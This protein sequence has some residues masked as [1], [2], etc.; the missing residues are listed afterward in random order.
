MAKAGTAKR[1]RVHGIEQ[2][3]LFQPDDSGWQPIEEFPDLRG[4]KAI[5]IDIESQD[6]NLDSKGPGFLRGDAKMVGFSLATFDGWKRYYPL[7]HQGGD[8]MPDPEKALRWLKE[9]VETPNVK[10]IGAN[11]TYELEGLHAAGINLQGDMLDVQVLQALLNEEQEGGYSLNNLCKLYL[12]RGKEEELLDEACRTYGVDKGGLWALPARYVGPYGADDAY[13]PMMIYNKQF[14]KLREEGLEAVAKIETDLIP[15]I[16]E[17]RKRGVRVDVPAAELLQTRL[18]KEE[19][20]DMDVIARDLKF[21]PDIWS[22][23][24]LKRVCDTK[25]IWD[26]PRT[27]KGN[28]SFKNDWLAQQEDPIFVKIGELRAKQKMR[29]DFVEG[30]ILTT[31]IRG[32]IH[33]QFH[34]TRRNSDSY[35]LQRT[36]GPSDGGDVEGT[37]SGRFSSTNPNLQQVPA[38]HPMWGKVIRALFVADVEE[39]WVKGDHAAQEPRLTAHIAK[40]INAPGADRI[41]EAYR[42]NP[43]LD[44][45][46]W[47]ADL[48]GISRKEAKTIN[49]GV[50]Y[51]MG[52]DKLAR[53]LGVNET[54]AKAILKEYDEAA[55]HIKWMN[56]R[57]M[58]TVEKRGFIRTITGRKRRFVKTENDWGRMV[59]K[60][61]HKAMNAGV[62]GSGAELIKGS[63][64]KSVREH[65]LYPSLTV[66]DELNWS[67]KKSTSLEVYGDIM[68]NCFQLHVQIRTELELGSSWGTL[69]KLKRE[70][71]A[72][73]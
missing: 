66:H 65:G 55:P 4:E 54:E 30:Q 43:D 56:T 14:D 58:E 60:G 39:E 34:S 50:A 57:A 29:R 53:S 17:M 21:A 18:L 42:E 2:G 24:D 44:T 25:G 38:R 64:V 73:V 72:N 3:I 62:Q 11:L 67:R 16:W 20:A 48:A 27:D 23:G 70:D 49:L 26:Y 61:I 33:C 69:K 15:I 6:P 46:Q 45:H 19:R 51:G 37:R 63:I 36:T 32:R 47:V 1:F 35:G 22:S 41:I 68:E 8:N 31:N 13:L 59:Y 9:Q 12:N 52:V 40:I 71:W 10:K 7:Y 28:P 5:G